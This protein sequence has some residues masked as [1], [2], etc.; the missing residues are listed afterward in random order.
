MCVCVT[1]F[2]QLCFPS[3]AVHTCAH[4]GSS[5]VQSKENSQTCSSCCGAVHILRAADDWVVD[6]SSTVLAL[7]TGC[8][9]DSPKL[10]RVCFS[11]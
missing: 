2:D 11:A 3:N 6:F 8:D 10:S 4:N 1:F 9:L 5:Y 7:M